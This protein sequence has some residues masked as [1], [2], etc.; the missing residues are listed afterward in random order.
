MQ[1]ILQQPQILQTAIYLIRSR[2]FY[3]LV[4]KYAEEQLI[5]HSSGPNR[6]AFGRWS[7]TEH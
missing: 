3:K 2:Y 6:R 5:Y 7:R 1:S 4:L